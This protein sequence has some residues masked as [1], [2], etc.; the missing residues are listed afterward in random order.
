MGVRYYS[1]V[2]EEDQEDED[3][4]GHPH[5][6]LV[7]VYQIQKF[8]FALV[9][10]QSDL[11][12]EECKLTRP[13]SMIVVEVVLTN[14]VWEEKD[15]N[16]VLRPLSPSTSKTVMTF[17]IKSILPNKREEDDENKPRFFQDNRSDCSCIGR[18]SNDMVSKDMVFVSGLQ[19][20]TSI[21]NDPRWVFCHELGTRFNSPPPRLW[22]LRF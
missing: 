5:H 19:Q 9:V 2:Y 16:R 14:G 4:G 3:N 17:D 12:D 20:Y 11:V 1:H 8:R 15:N 7:Q 10:K 21:P 13:S 18:L 22:C 6:E